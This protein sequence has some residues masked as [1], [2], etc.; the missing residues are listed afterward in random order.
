MF[1]DKR[2]GTPYI[3]FAHRDA[4]WELIPVGPERAVTR[5]QLLTAEISDLA[6]YW[7]AVCVETAESIRVAELTSAGLIGT[8]E[9][10]RNACIERAKRAIDQARAGR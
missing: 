5:E 9:R 7:H 6:L 4:E 10:D 1:Q 8:S 3:A 2:N